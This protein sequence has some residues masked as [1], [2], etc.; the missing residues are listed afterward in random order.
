MPVVNNKEVAGYRVIGAC[1]YDV[2]Y[3]IFV[4]FTRVDDDTALRSDNL[5]IV[6]KIPL[7]VC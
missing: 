1:A 7:A 5:L 6:N 3:R 4:F 2:L